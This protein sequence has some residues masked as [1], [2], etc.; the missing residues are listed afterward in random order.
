MVIRRG[1][2]WWASLGEPRGSG[3]GYRRPVV[4]VQSNAFNRSSIS[5]VMVATITSNLRLGDA[6][7]NVRLPPGRS[8]LANPCVVNVSQIL[9]IDKR[10]LTERLSRLPDQLLTKVDAGL[11]LALS[12]PH[13]G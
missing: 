10:F 9:T 1:E 7:G 11:R 13:G 5:T 12:L 8:K 4:V 2:I 6:P 3:P